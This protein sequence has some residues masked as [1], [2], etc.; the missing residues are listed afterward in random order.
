MDIRVE[1]RRDV[2]GRSKRFSR[3]LR[4]CVRP[5]FAYLPVT[6]S[7]LRFAAVLEWGAPLLLRAPSGTQVERVS[8]PGFRGEWI[9]PPHVRS[10]R[11]VLYIHGGAFFFGGLRT[12]R[13]LVA[14]IAGRADAMALSIAHRQLPAHPLSVS[15]DDALAA[16]RWLLDHGHDPDEVVVA[17]D[18]SG[19]FLAFTTVLAAAEQGLPAPAAIVAL[20]PLVRLDHPDRAAYPLT[21]RDAFM[22]VHRLARLERRLLAGAE[23]GPHPAPADRDLRPLPPVLVLAG[24]GEALR[25]D[26]ELI[27][28]RL[29]DA[30][31]PCRLQIWENQ[32]HVF[33][34][35]ADVVPEGHQAIAEIGAFIRSA[36]AH[37]ARAT[38]A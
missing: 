9:R 15:M 17:G 14:R 19:G 12:H 3:F 31:V 30:R 27:A 28:A 32:V 6:S 20:S 18:S 38:P 4:L 8:L 13:R 35:F 29:H 34:A 26:A 1:H 36:T 16:Y 2:S 25:Y 10:S 5:F 22:P 21:R 23:G 24:S 37:A 33:P 11:V 7:T